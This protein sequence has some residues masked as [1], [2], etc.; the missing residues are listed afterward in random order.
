MKT[1]D[2]L[3]NKA[4]KGEGEMNKLN[5]GCGWAWKREGWTGFDH[6]QKS[7]FP[8]EAWR[9]PYP[10][11]FFDI[12]FCSHMVE[13]IP[14][15]RLEETIS[16]INRVLKVGGLFRFLTPDLY[17]I[18]K[19]YIDG[20][21]E[22]MRQYIEEDAGGDCSVGGIKMDLGLAQAVLGFLHSPGFD[23]I[24]LSSRGDEITA[25]V[26]HC[27]MLDFALAENLLKKYGFTN[28]RKM[29][30]CE[31]EID[32]LKIPLHIIGE[33][34]QWNSKVDGD[35]A[36]N[37]G[38]TG[39]DRDPLISLIVEGR[40]ETHVRFLEGQPLLYGG[41]YKKL[42]NAK[43]LIL[44]RILTHFMRFANGILFYM[45]GIVKKMKSWTKKVARPRS[46]MGV[47]QS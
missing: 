16:E 17:K 40:K 13:H 8:H 47:K 5:L 27:S 37:H 11:G 46:L 24:V 3:Q 32:E 21:R 29:N 38:V 25:C 2:K 28:V 31:S 44:I 42:R 35:N 33:P 4:P 7:F 23:N 10:D 43:S 12:V 41:P 36:S 20:D 30:F 6:S 22:L 18:C 9:L 15:Q 34:P 26:A 39:F 14:V 19:A 45:T 1:A